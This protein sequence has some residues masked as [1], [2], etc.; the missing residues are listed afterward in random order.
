LLKIPCAVSDKFPLL[1]RINKLE[2]MAIKKI[3]EGREKIE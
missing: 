3:E 1:G 2:K